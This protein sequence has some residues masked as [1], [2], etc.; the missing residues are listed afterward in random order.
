MFSYVM[1]V[2]NSS[3]SGSSKKQLH[4]LSYSVGLGCRGVPCSLMG[5]WGQRRSQKTLLEP[6]ASFQVLSLSVWDR[7]TSIR[8]SCSISI[9]CA[10]QML[11]QRVPVCISMAPYGKPFPTIEGTVCS[12]RRPLPPAP[13]EV[14]RFTNK[15]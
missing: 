10:Y 13:A 6:V 8:S 3:P 2:K 9:T 4:T 15:Y 12:R 1:S 14:A 11:W 5:S 7:L